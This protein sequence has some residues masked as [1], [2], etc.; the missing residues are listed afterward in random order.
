MQRAFRPGALVVL[1]VLAVLLASIPSGEAH[2]IRYVAGLDEAQVGSVCPPDAIDQLLGL[3]ER[4]FGGA[5]FC[6]GHIV[7]NGYGEASLS[8]S[9]DLVYPVS[10]T[11][12]NVDQ[13]GC[14]GRTIQDFCLSVQLRDG[15]NW[16]SYSPTVVFVHGPANGNPAASPCSRGPQE[17][18]YTGGTT[19]I[20]S[21]SDPGDGPEA[22][23]LVAVQIQGGRA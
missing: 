19:G 7:P 9:D 10:G 18:L 20:V 17:H 6:P 11:V 4:Q 5:K 2:P 1:T 3:E 8:I 15:V 12:C 14:I 21:H 23:R 22:S 16:E 13:Y